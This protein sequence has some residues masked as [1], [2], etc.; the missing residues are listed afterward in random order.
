MVEVEAYV[1]VRAKVE[2]MAQT[3]QG[4]DVREGEADLKAEVYD[5]S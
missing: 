5:A 2:E 1:R 4:E 3:K